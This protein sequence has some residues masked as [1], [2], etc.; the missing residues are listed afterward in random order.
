MVKRVAG[1]LMKCCQKWCLSD[2]A[3]MVGGV[4][5]SDNSI[6]Y[7]VGWYVQL[8]RPTFLRP[9]HRRERTHVF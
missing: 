5:E 7:M 8:A 1:K 2:E 3:L 4:R 6:F 9:S